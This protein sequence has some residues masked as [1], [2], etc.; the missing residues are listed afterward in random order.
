MPRIEKR[1]DGFEEVFVCVDEQTGYRP[2]DGERYEPI[3]QTRRA[4]PLLARKGGSLNFNA[5]APHPARF[6]ARSQTPSSA[7]RMCRRRDARR[8]R[9]ETDRRPIES[10]GLRERT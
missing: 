3:E 2:R 5:F 9:V 7:V 10:R 6:P 1:F 4:G 8:V